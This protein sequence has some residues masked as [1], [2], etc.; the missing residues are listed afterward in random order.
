MLLFRSEEMVTAWCAAR[1]LPRRPIIT[2]PQLWQLAM[3]WYAN[4]MTP[5]SRRPAAKEMVGIFAGIGLDG[6]FWDPHS[7]E[8]RA[9]GA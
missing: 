2:L 7:D 6:P 1:G 3:A 9:A 5:E 8:W 4:R